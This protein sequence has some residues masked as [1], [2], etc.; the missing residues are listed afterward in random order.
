MIELMREA[1]AAVEAVAAIPSGSITEGQFKAMIEADSARR[2]AFTP[3]VI[4][5]LLALV[6]AVRGYREGRNDWPEIHAA[7][8]EIDSPRPTADQ[9]SK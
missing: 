2:R 5:K 8:R 6:D 9:E 3:E 7:I 1:L 4:K